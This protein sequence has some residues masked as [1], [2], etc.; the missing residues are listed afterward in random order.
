MAH[1][2]HPLVG[3]RAYGAAMRTKSNRLPPELKER[4]DAFPRQALHAFLLQFAHPGTG[5]VMRFTAPAPADMA[6]LVTAFRDL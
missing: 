2:G 6:A 3:D 4:V 5:E 1:I